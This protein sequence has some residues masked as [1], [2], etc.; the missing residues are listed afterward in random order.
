[1][2][3][4]TGHATG[5]VDMVGDAPH[6]REE[7]ECGV[8]E[9]GR[10]GL[11]SG[12]NDD[13][14]RRG[15][16][17]R[18]GNSGSPPP[19]HLGRGEHAVGTK[20]SVARAPTGNSRVGRG[21]ACGRV[22][23]AHAGARPRPPSTAPRDRPCAG[24]SPLR[25]AAAVQPY[26]HPARP[27]AVCV[28]GIATHAAAAN[29]H[30]LDEKAHPGKGADGNGPARAPPPAPPPPTARQQRESPPPPRGRRSPSLG[31]GCGATRQG[32]V[33]RASPVTRWKVWL[34][35][36]P[37][38]GVWWVRAPRRPGLGRQREKKSADAA[39]IASEGPPAAR[40]GGGAP[41][42]RARGG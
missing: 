34:P 42:E 36:P 40:M 16:A 41:R 38:G 29:A 35:W 23:A 18:G 32:A 3:L 12:R 26:P 8:P 6:P 5:P 4:A 19:R 33:G 1:M 31:G 11:G 24:A 2:A 22:V 25:A 28:A 14:E 9:G 21:L 39:G 7:G 17:R 37:A 10:E 20:R 30:G 27:P 15:E 13:G